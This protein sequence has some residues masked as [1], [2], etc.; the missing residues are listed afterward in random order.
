MAILYYIAIATITRRVIKGRTYYYAVKAGRVNGKP[1]LIWQKYM[2]TADDIIR[3]YQESKQPPEIK[4]V[5]VFQ[6]GAEASCLHI[7]ALV[8][9]QF[10]ISLFPSG[11]RGSAW[12]NT[13][14]LQLSTAAASQ[15]ANGVW[16]GGF[17]NRC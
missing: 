8:L 15:R 9:C 7:A 1:R 2:G 3:Q 4:T 5:R 14:L 13:F 6:P 11:D 10:S 16:V 12:E 17:S